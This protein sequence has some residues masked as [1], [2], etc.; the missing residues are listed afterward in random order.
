M[1]R[2]R[3]GTRRSAPPDAGRGIRVLL[4]HRI[5]PEKTP[6]SPE[7]KFTF[8]RQFRGQLRLLERWGFTPVTF[9]DYRLIVE[10]ELISPRKPIILT[11]DDGYKDTYEIAAPILLEFGMSAVV[12]VLGDRT[13]PTNSW[14]AGL[15]VPQVELLNDQNLLELHQMGFEIGSHSLT[16]ARLTMLPRED[17]WHE[18]QRSRV[19]LEITL[20]APVKTFAYPYGLVNRTLKEMVAAAGFLQACGVWSGPSRFQADPFEIRRIEITHSTGLPEF[21]VKVLGP[22]PALRTIRA[23]TRIILAGRHQPAHASQMKTLLLVSAGLGW[24]D[25]GGFEMREAS[26]MFPRTLPLLESLNADVLDERFLKAAPRRRSAAYRLTGI[27]I[28]QVLEAFAVRKN[29]DAIVS[30]GEHLGL[31]LAALLRLTR[32]HTPHVA[33]FS[34]ISKPKKA[35]ILRMVHPAIDRIILMS[36][37]QADFGRSKLHIPPSKIALLRWPVDQKFWRPLG[38]PQDMICS[39]GREMRDYATFVEALRTLDIPCHIAAGGQLSVGKDDS[40]KETLGKDGSLPPNVTAGP[41]NFSDL[42]N[43]YNRSRFFV[44]PLLETETDNGTT[45]ILEAMSMGKAVICSR[46]SGQ[47]DVIQ[48]GITGIFVPPGDPAALRE[49]IRYLWSN[50]DIAAEMGARAREHIERFHAYDGWVTD[51]Q[52]VIIDAIAQRGS[53]EADKMRR[54]LAAPAE[55]PDAV[56]GS[57]V[58]NA[59][60]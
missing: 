38:G 36:S 29:Y 31:P 26:D 8:E 10:G 12:F 11:F 49:A 40:W 17:A 46:V 56:S 60:E 30:W 16:H 33:I 18:I 55:E 9:N 45:S 3:S 34:W 22:Y 37:A 13:V 59:S 14:D 54:P 15:N 35:H 1:I 58:L 25:R 5:L 32:S 48:E 51:V 50:P 39:A 42:R 52:R 24:P 57:P 44:M 27:N 2:S 28:A 47:R 6:G 21:G 4:Y 43:L 53:M 19:L 23:R 20:N 41:M 7:I